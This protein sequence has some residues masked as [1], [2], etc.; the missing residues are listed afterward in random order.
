MPFHSQDS[1]NTRVPGIVPY[2]DN[3]PSYVSVI[4]GSV[5]RSTYSDGFPSRLIGGGGVRSSAAGIPIINDGGYGYG[6]ARSGGRIRDRIRSWWGRHRGRRADRGPAVIFPLDVLVPGDEAVIPDVN[7][8]TILLPR[9]PV[10]LIPDFVDGVPIFPNIVPDGPTILPAK[11]LGSFLS[12]RFAPAM[13]LP[14]RG[15]SRRDF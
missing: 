9:R 8:P 2:H 15:L 3:P 14:G 6:N 4:G 5:G 13:Y 12:N 1:G 7:G 10:K 11:P